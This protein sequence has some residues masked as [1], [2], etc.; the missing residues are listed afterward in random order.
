ME[1]LNLYRQR[2]G[3]ESIEAVDYNLLLMRSEFEKE[4]AKY[5][6]L[7]SYQSLGFYL[8]MSRVFQLRFTAPEPPNHK[9]P[10]NRVASELQELSEFSGA[11][12][13]CDYAGVYVFR[14]R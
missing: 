9:H 12:N 2:A 11:F 7:V 8:F 5:F 4:A 1:G 10:I 14:R 6:E 3:F 13:E